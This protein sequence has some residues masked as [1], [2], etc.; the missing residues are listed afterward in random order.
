MEPSIF[1]YILRHTAKDQIL[2]LILTLCSLPFLYA[3]LEVPKLII[4]DAIGGADLPADLLGYPVDQLSYLLI[5]CLTFLVLV[6]ING[7]IKYVLNVY[8]GVVGERMLRRLRYDLFSRILRFPVPHFKKVSQ[9]EIIPIITAETEPLG[10]FIGEAFAL[11]AFQGGILLTYLFFIFNQD[12]LLGIVATALYPFQMYVIPKLQRKVN[13][14]GKQRVLAARKLG[15]RIGDS[16]SGIQ[17]VHAHDTSHYERA[18]ISSRLSRIYQIRFEIYKKKFFIKFLNNFLAQVT[19]FFFYLF[20]GYYII[21]GELSLGALVAVL[22]AYKDL[23]APWKELLKFYQTKEDV[24]IKYQQIIEQ[25]QP[26]AMLDARLQDGPLLEL[27]H[28]QGGWQASNISYSEQQGIN[29][30]DKL[31]FQLDLSSH[32]AIVGIGASGKEELGQLL[33]RLMMPSQGRLSLAGMDMQHLPESV[34]GRHLAHVGANAHH[35]AGS[36]RDNLLYSLRHRQLEHSGEESERQKYVRDAELTGN[37]SDDPQADWIDIQSMGLEN[38]DALNTHIHQVLAQSDL[39]DDLFQ[40]GLLGKIADDGQQEL[41]TRILQAREQI[42]HH[43]REG[44]YQGLV[45]LFDWDSYNSNL[46]VLENIMFSPAKGDGVDRDKLAG[47]ERLQAFLK[48]QDL[49]EEF[50]SIGRELT[51]IMVDLFSDVDEDSDLFERFSFISAE[52]LPEYRELLKQT[53]DGVISAD[54]KLLCERFLALTFRLCPARH[55]LGLIDEVLQQRILQ[56]RRALVDELAD[57]DINLQFFDSKRYNPDLNL[58]D[59]MLFGRLV[60]GQAKAEEKVTALIRQVVCEL[61]LEQGIADVG[62][63]FEVGTAGMR[64]SLAQRQKLAIARALIK[65]PDVVILNEATAGL[66]PAAESRILG[67]LREALQG[68]GLV[69]ITSRAD[70]VREFDHVLVLD[71]GQLVEQGSF[72]QLSSNGRHLPALIS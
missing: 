53:K 21:Q 60:Y 65:L 18:V 34:M 25:F 43:L 41:E 64:L 70:Q 36:I 67:N 62:L 63:D 13:A 50:L 3:T 35:F 38:E 54:D 71:R 58:Q 6:I 27:D 8:R 23:S 19:P 57:S 30:V 49:L 47:N 17:E 1:R 33:A 39:S 44:R 26:E 69:H 10:G 14:L 37:S 68:R 55:R 42:H 32:T 46:T 24:R 56:A 72:E 5:L 22:A 45:E 40:L 48:K 11:P 16:I 31:S 28:S 15:D 52:E 20:G 9:G 7:G 2:I 59:N 51:E 12:V 61:G 4:N 66:D 29:L